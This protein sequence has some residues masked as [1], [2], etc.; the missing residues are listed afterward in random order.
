MRRLPL[1]AVAILAIG[2][3][4]H[5]GAVP[6]PTK[7]SPQIFQQNPSPK[8]GWIVTALPNVQG[9]SAFPFGIAADATHH[10]WVADAVDG[11]H[12][13]LREI[14]MDQHV[15]TFPLSISIIN[16]A[17]GPDHNLW[18]PSIG[19]PNPGIVA[20]V[21]PTGT[22]TD[23]TVASPNT[24]FGNIITGPDG[25]LW[26]AV[27]SSDRSSGGVGTI[28][29]SGSAKFYP[30]ECE[31]TVASGSDGNIWFGNGATISNM[32]TQGVLIGQH[33]IGDDSMSIMVTG[34][35]HALY[36]CADKTGFISE[37]I[38]VAMDGTV[39]HVGG[40]PRDDT[41][42]SLTN[43]PDGDLWIS[44]DS[45]KHLITFDPATQSYGSTIINSPAFGNLVLGQDGNFWLADHNHS[46]VYTYVR[47]AIT[48]APRPVTVSVGH[49]VDLN[50]SETNYA[51]QWTAIS[52]KP[53]IVGVTPNSNLGKFVVT[54]VSPGTTRITVYDSMFNSANVKVTVH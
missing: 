36:F 33:S 29:T 6:A 35:D 26:Y 9:Q 54:G 2:C 39:T 32:T 27:C 44:T 18:V 1:L 13:A 37:L 4:S 42:V 16:V 49:T 11:I 3:S 24:A 52:S 47:S 30:G 43:G 48:L 5:S 14:A 40:D 25:A 12:G 23:F 22:E 50:V 17:V 53:S 21:T 8:S 34:S 45:G 20:R 28:T 38:R 31:F 41:L 7:V 51:A 10:I 46:A 15:N 19:N